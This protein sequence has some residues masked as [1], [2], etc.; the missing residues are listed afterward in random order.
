MSRVAARLPD[1]SE[2][3]WQKQVI[4][5]AHLLGWRVAHFRTA[6]NARGHHMTPVAAD[7]AGFPDLILVRDRVIV[8]ELKTRTGK[9]SAAQDAWLAAFTAAGISAYCWRP[10]DTH[11]IIDTLR[12]RSAA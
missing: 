11:E 9:T 5:L 10:A 8:A 7:G 12:R 2:A 4:E 6:M 3:E 1:I